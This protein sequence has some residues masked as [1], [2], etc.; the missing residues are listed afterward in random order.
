MKKYINIILIIMIEMVGLGAL[1]GSVPHSNHHLSSIQFPNSS[2]IVKFYRPNLKCWK[3]F[4]MQGGQSNDVINFNYKHNKIIDK[5]GNSIYP[6]MSITLWK[7]NSS[8]I[9][10][11]MF[12]NK[13]INRYPLRNTRKIK[14]GDFI[15]LQG[16]I[17]YG[18]HRH[19][20]R[21]TF[22]CTKGVGVDL[23]CDSTFSV[24]P[25]VVKDFEYWLNTVDVINEK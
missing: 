19:I 6:V 1:K 8:E 9:N 24:Y 13:L 25:Q 12:A 18:G 4:V 21:R 15:Y 2:I 17:D 11:D 22:L 23:T 20:V 14:R 10:I 5:N 16:T 3:P 7:L